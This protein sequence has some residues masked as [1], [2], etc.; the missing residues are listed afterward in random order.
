MDE[1]GVI[2]A[3]G[4]FQG[5]D[6]F[7]ARPAVV[8]ALREEGRIVAEVR[9]YV[10]AVGHCSRCGTTVEPRQSLQWFVRVAP[11]AKAAGYVPRDG[12]VR[13]SPPERP[14][15]G[16][17]AGSTTC[18]T[19]PSAA[20]CGGATV[21]QFFMDRGARSAVLPAFGQG[22]GRLASGHHARLSAAGHCG[23]SPR[24]S[25]TRRNGRQNEI[26]V[27]FADPGAIKLNFLAKVPGAELSLGNAEMAFYYKDSFAASHALEGYEHLI[28]MAMVGDQSLFT[29]SDGIERRREIPQPLLDNPP[30][31]E[32]YAKGSWGPE[33]VKRLVAPY[34]W[35][36]P[37]V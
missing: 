6:R 1:H 30:P 29:R 5:L 12:R 11:L 8:A 33:S 34:H 15:P 28:L 35:H 17:S 7:E 9:P 32:P 24:I 19:G 31:V 37:H 18:T 4:P 22:H 21:F 25:G 23:C 16:T 26:V 13:L 27:D 2:T 3:H 20:S 14:T 10:H 36:L